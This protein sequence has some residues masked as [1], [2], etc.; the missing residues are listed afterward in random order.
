MGVMPTSAIVAISK[1][2]VWG[3]LGMLVCL[4]VGLTA[5][6]SMNGK[7]PWERKE[8]SGEVAPAAAEW[9]E[10]SLR[11]FEPPLLKP[12]KNRYFKVPGHGPV[13]AMTFD[14]GP[15][16]WTMDLLD[17]LKEREIKATFFV[18]GS[19]VATYPEVV[20][21]MVTEGH[22]IAN[23]T[24]SHPSNMARKPERLVRRELQACH[25][26]I[27]QTTGVT[28]RL[29]RPPGG[30][31]TQ[32]QSRWIY[33]EWDYVNV[34]WSVD[35]LDWKRPGAEVIKRRVVEGAHEGAIILAHDLH[36]P[37]VRAM[38]A[39]LDA[40]LAEGYTFL[41]VS[42]LLA[43][44]RPEAQLMVFPAEVHAKGAELRID[45]EEKP[46]PVEVIRAKVLTP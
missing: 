22:E 20:Q 14:D 13:V 8:A 12:P 37:T 3:A 4:P 46:Q 29:F 7:L 16:P 43:L 38:P 42:E 31:F 21:R 30:S 44:D 41:R 40:L 23:H 15:R 33:D 39:T 32:S 17:A 19:A 36:Q 18:V 26:I 1:G 35:P 11:P 2:G 34:M 25:D 24:W 45:A 28:P 10:S 9:A 5:C 27:V 6:S